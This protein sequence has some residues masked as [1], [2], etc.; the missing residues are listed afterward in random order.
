MMD[1]PLR[2][3]F[4]TVISMT[5]W[6]RTVK[7]YLDQVEA[8]LWPTY[9]SIDFISLARLSSLN[10]PTRRASTGTPSS[11]HPKANCHWNG[12]R[13]L[14][15]FRFSLSLNWAAIHNLRDQWRSLVP[16]Q[17]D[18]WPAWSGNDMFHTE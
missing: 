1:T 2:T 18:T 9:L 16:N 7:Q 12:P 3:L 17:S 6:S 8:T 13:E 14:W 10:A 15:G 11:F 5:I 4:R